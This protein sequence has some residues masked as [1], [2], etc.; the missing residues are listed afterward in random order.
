MAA[1]GEGSKVVAISGVD[2]IGDWLLDGRLVQGLT[3]TRSLTYLEQ[4][5]RPST[6]LKH[7]YMTSRISWRDVQAPRG[8]VRFLCRFGRDSQFLWL[9]TER[10]EIQFLLDGLAFR[11]YV[12]I[13]GRVQLRS[14]AD[15]GQNET[16]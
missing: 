12:Y 10:K 11:K 1:V 9:A 15:L 4:Q 13:S 7:M 16:F 5:Q 6:C 14:N 2:Q 3:L 8:Y